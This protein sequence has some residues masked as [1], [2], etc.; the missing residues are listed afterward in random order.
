[1]YLK[2]TMSDGNVALTP[3]SPSHTLRVIDPGDNTTAAW[4]FGGIV[5]IDLEQGDIVNGPTTSATGGSE[6]DAPPAVA[7]SEP[8]PV[9]A[10]SEPDPAPV[11]PPV[12]DPAPADPPADPAPVDDPAHDAV[13]ATVTQ[14]IADVA[15][16]PADTPKKA[17]TQADTIAQIGADIDAALAEFPDSPQLQ[18]AKAQLAALAGAAG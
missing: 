10:P 6:A 9:D 15:A 16:A 14:A 5:S 13:V 8:A 12:A 4:A 17:A 11:D 2:V 1:M 18:D 3:L 7:P